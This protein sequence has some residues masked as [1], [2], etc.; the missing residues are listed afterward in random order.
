[1]ANVHTLID[2]RGRELTLPVRPKRIVSLVPSITESLFELGA[3]DRVVGVTRYCV[4]PAAARER[5]AV[6]GGTHGID[7]ERVR[8]LEPDLV[9]ANQEENPRGEIETLLETVPTFVTFPRTVTDGIALIRTLGRLAALPAEAEASAVD[10]EAAHA[11][12]VAAVPVRRPRV[13]YLIWRK[14]WIA[15][16]ADTY[17]HDMLDT[18]GAV[19][20]TAT[21]PERYPR[22]SEEAVVALQPDAILLSTEP[23]A[24]TP[25]HAE[26]WLARG[27]LAAAQFGQVPIV[28]GELCSWYG[29]RV[30]AGLRYLSRRICALRPA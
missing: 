13:L 10:A 9:I 11:A 30:A 12:A 4:H 29:T 16:S 28:D 1:M 26:E 25:A 6:V 20:V 27:D 22:L 17:V 5:A 21:A 3:G 23:Y 15:V 2:A 8:A 14:P 18:C 19:N 24:F 7:L